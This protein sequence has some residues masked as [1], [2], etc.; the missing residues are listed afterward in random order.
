[1][2]YVAISAVS[3]QVFTRHQACTSTLSSVRSPG[4]VCLTC[5]GPG[6]LGAQLPRPPPPSVPSSGSRPPSSR[7]ECAAQ[8]WGHGKTAGRALTSL[9]AGPNTDLALTMHFQWDARVHV[10]AVRKVMSS[11]QLGTLRNC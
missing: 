4:N 3:V 2:S 8:R 11:N 5:G 7:K 1:M 9:L 6:A 10:A